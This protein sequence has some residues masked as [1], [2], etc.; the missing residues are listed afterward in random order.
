MDFYALGLGILVVCRVTHLLD[1]EDGPWNL[2]VRFRQLMGN[3]FWGGLLDCF[4]CLSLWIALPLAFPLGASWRE[5]LLLWPAL[6]AGAILLE[7]ST[8]TREHEPP[9]KYWKNQEEPNE[10][11][12]KEQKAPSGGDDSSDRASH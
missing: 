10:L 9:I 11:L 8:A 3:G 5:R 2:L 7:R 6:S 4:Y 1:A 12:W